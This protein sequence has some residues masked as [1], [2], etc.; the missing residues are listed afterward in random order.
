[1]R[2]CAALFVWMG[3]VAL[4]GAASAAEAPE[5][6]GEPPLLVTDAENG[7]TVDVCVGRGIVIRL[8]GNITT[9]YSWQVDGVEGDAVKPRGKV[10]YAENRTPGVVGA[11][12][13]FAA[14]FDAVKAGKATIK[15]GYKRP[16][17]KD[18]P[19]ARTFTV[20]VNVQEPPL[21]RD[22]ADVEKNV[23]KTVAVEGTARAGQKGLARIEGPQGVIAVASGLPAEAIGKQV[24][25]IGFAA[26][27]PEGGVLVKVVQW[28]V[29]R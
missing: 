10:A 29:I 22:A 26:R 12:G 15:M 9:G 18:R 6:A 23:G 5:P 20:T 17:E 3:A 24:R 28:E 1:M 13:V 16:W 14:A 7:K 19:P 27:P 4:A 11:P 25:V 8:K 2:S 21:A